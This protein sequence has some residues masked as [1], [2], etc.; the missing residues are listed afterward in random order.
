MELYAIKLSAEVSVVLRSEWTKYCP[1][2]SVRELLVTFHWHIYI[3]IYIYNSP[4]SRPI[5]L[6]MLFLGKY[7]RQMSSFDSLQSASNN[8]HTFS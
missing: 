5:C 4:T 3:Y 1:M 6:D 8:P 2:L 7:A